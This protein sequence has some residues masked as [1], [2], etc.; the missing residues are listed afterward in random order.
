MVGGAAGVDAVAGAPRSAS[1]GTRL[2]V[3]K[4]SSRPRRSPLHHGAAQPE[5]AHPGR[6]GVL[7]VA[8]GH[9]G[10]GCGWRRRSRPPPRSARPPGSRTR[11][12]RA[13]ARRRRWRG[14][15]SGSSRPPTRATAPKSLDQHLV[16]EVLGADRREL[17]V[18]G[19]HHHL[20]HPQVGQQ[21]GLER[22]CVVSSLGIA[23]GWITLSGCGS[24]VSTVSEP[25]IT[26]RWPMCTPSNWPTATRRSRGRGLVERGDL[27]PFIRRESLRRA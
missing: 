26:S 3:G 2:A 21:L 15:R 4:P 19:D 27:H 8:G 17:A 20:L 11:P 25:R 18:E 6:S 7:D 23:S 16:D 14:G 10:R 5:G 22:P 24:N 1:S 13:A 9:A 12:A